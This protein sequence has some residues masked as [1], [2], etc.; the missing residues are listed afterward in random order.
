MTLAVPEPLHAV[1][2]GQL[3]EATWILLPHSQG[4]IAES[5]AV[6][7]RK[8]LG[9]ATTMLVGPGLG[10][11]DET[12]KFMDAFFSLAGKHERSSIGFV[13]PANKSEPRMSLACHRWWWMQMD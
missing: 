12:R 13:H 1:L 10:L 4:V 9:R 3:P 7:L 8:E 5:A 2:A 6:L 11:D